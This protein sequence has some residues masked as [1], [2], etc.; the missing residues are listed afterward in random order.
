MG[1]LYAIVGLLMGVVFSLVFVFAGLAGQL[2]EVTG[3]MRAG[4]LGFML[5]IGSIIFFPICYGILGAV[6]GL[7]AAALYN[8]I[9]KYTG[10]IEIELG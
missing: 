6:G 10:G 5:G 4:P 8:V 1:V 3:G 9:A 7:I 2:S